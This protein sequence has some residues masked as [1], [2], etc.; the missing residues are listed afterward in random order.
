MAYYFKRE[1]IPISFLVN[2]LLAEGLVLSRKFWALFLGPQLI[3]VSRQLSQKCVT[4]ECI[5][6]C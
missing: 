5:Y 4:G 3:F 2:F 1:N 6:T